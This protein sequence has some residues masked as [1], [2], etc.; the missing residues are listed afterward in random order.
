MFQHF[1]DMHTIL[2]KNELNYHLR[3]FYEM[4][5]VKNRTGCQINTRTSSNYINNTN[6][7]N[8]NMELFLSCVISDVDVTVQIVPPPYVDTTKSMSFSN[9][10]ILKGKYKVNISIKNDDKIQQILEK[11]KD[12]SSKAKKK[13]INNKI[14]NKENKFTGNTTTNKNKVINSKNNIKTFNNTKIVPCD[15]YP[16]LVMYKVNNDIIDEEKDI[17]DNNIFI[18]IRLFYNK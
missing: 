12:S 14:S 15:M 18:V 17:Q 7:T 2:R 10:N 5:A 3:F 6:N 16:Q 4:Q 11:Q 9:T 1:E 13:Y 8:A